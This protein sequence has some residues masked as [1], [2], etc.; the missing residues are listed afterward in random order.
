MATP[1]ETATTISLA[2]SPGEQI[3]F[4]PTGSES[5]FTFGDYRVE[6]D[7]GPDILT[8]TSQNLQFTPFSTLNNLGASGFS[9]NFSV[10]VQNNELK[11]VH[12]DPYSYTYFG[13]FYTEVANAINNVINDFPYAALAY[14]SFEGDTIIDYSQTFNNITGQKLSTFKV[15][16][17][18][19][20]NQGF[21]L[22]GS[23]SPINNAVSLMTNTNMFEI[24]LSGATTAKTDSYEIK[25]YSFTAGTTNILEFEI[26]G[27]LFEDATEA[28]T[29]QTNSKLP[30]YIRPSR[31]RMTEYNRSISRI[32]KQL[33]GSG[34]LDIPDVDDEKREWT[35]RVP[36][37]RTIDGFNPDTRG[38]NFETFKDNVLLL[39]GNVDMDKTDIMLK[40]MLPDNYLQFDSDQQI[41]KKLTSSYAKQFDE[42]KNFIDNMA[43]A[44]TIT[45]NEEENIPDKFLVK[46]SNLLGWKL[47]S[48]FNEIDLFDY[49]AND[50]DLQGNQY[51]YYNIELWKRILIN[52][53]WLYKRKGTR[54]ALQ[55]LFK[56]MGA[57]DCLIVF[58]EF[59]YEID[60][61]LSSGTT[62][63]IGTPPSSLK[64]NP[65]G[66][67]NYEWSNLEFQE[68]GLGRGTGQAYINQW[69]P[70]FNPLKK[71]DNIKVQVGDTGFTGSENIMNTKELC[72][73]LDPANAIECDVFDWY[74]LSGTCWVWGSS[75]PPFSANTVPFEYAI[76]DCEFVN[77]DRITGMTFNDYMEFI[78]TSNIDPTNRKTNDQGHTMFTYPELKKIYMNYYLLA[79]PQ[80]NRLTIKKLEAFLD[81]MEV[82]FQ[83]YLLQLIPATTILECQGT[84]YRNTVFHRQKFVYK[85]GINKG[86][87]FQNSLPPD[88]RPGVT[89]IKVTS[90]VN[91]F[92][93]ATIN[94][95]VINSDV[96]QGIRSSVNAI[97]IKGY[98]NVN[99]IGTGIEGFDVSGDINLPSGSSS[100]SLSNAPVRISQP[101][102][103]AGL[104]S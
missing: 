97:E 78:Y 76:D 43:Y 80:S 81:L 67:P 18:V 70:E 11:P 85:D 56:L 24:Q 69:E 51:A 4:A 38:A 68:G 35:Y 100:L 74:K 84:T 22:F 30:L 12:K 9:P 45:Y 102:N 17:D 75:A 57:P 15:P 95:I 59:I 50:Q 33:L 93:K 39:A 36:W 61:T 64:T 16:L 96:S 82:N 63:P 31:K 86:S 49:L 52:I 73:T 103:L 40:T 47:S 99:N 3:L 48:T 94:P 65:R 71:V 79:E 89:P 32:E 41:Y 46:L 27:H 44:H 92:Q 77:P 104:S 25:S 58:N 6:R 28:Y 19:V 53:N 87:E 83:D 7:G 1:A 62:V 66:Y 14:D 21:I 91:D 37:P 55:F 60:S 20:T 5:I 13:S 8:G 90:K 72:A 26:Y 98:I 42:I 2:F 54:D 29:G 34:L 10:S 23:G 101:A 88:I